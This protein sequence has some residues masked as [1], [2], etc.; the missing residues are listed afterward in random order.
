MAEPDDLT[1]IRELIALAHVFIEDLGP[2]VFGT[3]GAGPDALSGLNPNLSLLSRPDH[4][5]AIPLA[6]S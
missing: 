3:P 6:T 1:P 5:I 4:C 2:E